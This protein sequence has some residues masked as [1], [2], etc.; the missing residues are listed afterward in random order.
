MIP[1]DYPP[2]KYEEVLKNDNSDSIITDTTTAS[3]FPTLLPPLTGINTANTNENVI[4][5]TP[6]RVNLISSTTPIF[7]PNPI[8]TDCPYCQVCIIF[9]F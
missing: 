2:P 8:E 5:V 9:F 4:G 6:F 7:G 1:D 3:S